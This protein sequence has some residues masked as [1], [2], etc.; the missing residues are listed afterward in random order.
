MRGCLTLPRGFGDNQESKLR[1]VR[2]PSLEEQMA[3]EIRKVTIVGSGPAGCTAAIYT[4]RAQLEPFLFEGFS[5]GGMPGGQLMTTTDVENFPG[6]PEGINAPELMMRMKQQAKR[7][8]TTFVMEDVGE[9][10]FSVR[11]FVVRGSKTTVSSQTVI[12]STGAVARR[13]G[14]TGEQEFWGKGVS[15]CAVCDG[16]LPIFRGQRLAVIGGGDS[17]CEEALYLTHFASKVLML[18]RRD[19]LRAS[20]VLQKTVID[21]PKIEIMWLTS[22]LEFV[23]NE[24]MTGIRVR[25]NKTGEVRV[26]EVRGAFYAVGHIP[27]TDFLGGQLKLGPNGYIKVV[28]GKCGT[29][30]EGVFA[31]GDVQDPV[32]RQAVSAAGSGCMAAIEAERWLLEK[33]AAD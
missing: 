5:V 30:V 29:S 3:Q 27:N 1:P 33:S 11:P 25:N 13:L 28:H 18:V 26:L 20:K 22:P 17:A 12:V 21:N 10:D 2:W 31:C 15:A 6:F 4:A 24:T 16:G 19:V 23:G 8:G 7:F 14:L 9:V 32:Y